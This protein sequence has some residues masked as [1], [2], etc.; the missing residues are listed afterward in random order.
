VCRAVTATS[1]PSAHHERT[2][3]STDAGLRPELG[4]AGGRL[5]DRLIA[6]LAHELRNPLASL[7]GHAQLLERALPPGE[8]PRGKAELVVSEAQRLE[9]LV[10][11][12]LGFVRTGE[13]K[14]APVDLAA[15][16][17]AV[18]EEH[19]ADRI[20]VAGEAP[21]IVADGDRLRQV[22]ANLVDN[23][24]QSCEGI[25][26]LI[27]SHRGG[28]VELGVRD[29]GPGIAPADL[30]HLF[31][32]FFTTRSHGTGLG[33]AIARQIVELHGG[34][35]SAANAEGGGARFTLSLP[36]GVA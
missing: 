3:R 9:R 7:K 36:R 17:Q 23:A 11:D 31:E 26:E 14:R 1:E 16:A 22:I 15:L 25:V 34:T 19:G 18:A 8:P 29:H 24:L 6:T 2:E 35:L 33:L 28:D 30:P 27:I 5:E 32:P 4:K 10:T 12:L 20:L 13:L 21:P